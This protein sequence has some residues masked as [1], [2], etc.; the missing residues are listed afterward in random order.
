MLTRDPDE[1]KNIKS[2]VY[3]IWEYPTSKLIMSYRGNNPYEIASLT[4]IMT[5]YTVRKICMEYAIDCSKESVVVEDHI[6]EVTGTSAELLGGEI[7]TIEELLYGLMLPSGNDAATCLA[8]WG[9]RYLT[10]EE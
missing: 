3:V 8:E 1:L 6:M 7:Y 4:K 10:M 9:G 2:D 5:F